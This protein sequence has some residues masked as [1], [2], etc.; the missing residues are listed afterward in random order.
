MIAI[1]ATTLIQEYT[2]RH[3][4]IIDQ[5]V[6]IYNLCAANAIYFYL[7][8]LVSFVSITIIYVHGY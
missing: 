3:L 4:T 2:I 7:H 5:Y 8:I 1:I 6:G